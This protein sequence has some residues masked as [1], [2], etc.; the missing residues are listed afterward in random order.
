MM[1]RNFK[2]I[3][4]SGVIAASLLPSKIST[5]VTPDRPKP[6]KKMVMVVKTTEK[7]VLTQKERQCLALN[8]YHE[9]GIEP[10]E[11]KLAVAQVTL[12]RARDGKWGNDICTVVYS[13]S[14]FSWT[15]DKKK[16]F[17]EPKGEL[18]VRSVQAVHKFEQ[19]HRIVNLDSSKFYHADYIK[20][21]LWT[22]TMTVVNKIGQHIFYN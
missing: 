5:Q 19:G 9:A 11:G 4:V 22:K 8:V 6:I 13:K 10:T 16:K 7:V 21:P 20:P 12:N 14:Q 15:K 17:K 2:L 3:T 18:W 1:N